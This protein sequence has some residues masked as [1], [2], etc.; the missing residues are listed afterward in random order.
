LRR[1]VRSSAALLQP[2]V[3]ARFSRTI[4]ALAARNRWNDVVALAEPLSAQDERVPLQITILRGDAL[5]RL[6]RSSDLKQLIA[7]LLRNPALKRKR[8]PNAMIEIAELLAAVDEYDAA[9]RLLER[10]RG[11][12]DLPG[13]TQRIEQLTL[14]R[15][16][17]SAYTTLTTEHFDIRYPRD[18]PPERGKKI[19]DI[20]EA[21]LRRLRASWFPPAGHTKRITVD[22]LSWED[23][24]N[25]TGSEYILGLFTNKLFLPI[26]NVEHFIPEVVA[27]MTHELTHALIAEATN[28]LAPRWFHEA[29]ASRLEMDETSRNA[30]QIYRD[31]RFL[32]VSLLDAVA[33][34]SPDPELIVESYQIGETTLRFVEAKY[35]K[36]AIARMIAAFRNG[37]TT[38]EAVRIATNGSVAD[39]DRLARAWGASQPTLFT[40][41]IVRYDDAVQKRGTLSISTGRH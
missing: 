8:D 24:Q 10:A 18:M 23:F 16:L 29:L 7:D 34:G 27:I 32:T 12:L 40:D 25:Y 19:G 38:D 30:F 13:I 39:L 1:D 31:E 11:D 41:A 14:E 17:A 28:N 26:A 5:S 20:L 35:G 2:A 36:A 9:I 22:V 6:G 4:A 33:G 21:E 37:A 3:R 15:Q